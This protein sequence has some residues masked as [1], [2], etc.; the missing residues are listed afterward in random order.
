ME[1]L[2]YVHS[3]ERVDVC[4]LLTEEERRIRLF[5]K[6]TPPKPT[7]FPPTDPQY[8][9]NLA[10]LI[11][12]RLL[13][14]KNGKFSGHAKDYDDWAE[15][16]ADH[17]GTRHRDWPTFTL[18]ESVKISQTGEY[19]DDQKRKAWTRVRDL[20]AS[21]RGKLFTL[22]EYLIYFRTYW[23]QRRDTEKE[24]EDWVNLK[25][26]GS[27]QAFIRIVR[28]KASEL[29]PPAETREIVRVIYGGLKRDVRKAMQRYPKLTRPD[30]HTATEEWLDWI[31]NLDQATYTH[32]RRDRL[33][34]VETD[35][36]S[37]SSDSD[38]T[39]EDDYAETFNA[40]R[41]VLKKSRKRSDKKITKKKKGEQRKRSRRR[42]SSDAR[43]PSPS[44]EKVRKCWYCDEPG[45]F[46]RNCRK[47]KADKE[48]ENKEKEKEGKKD[49]KKRKDST[50]S[51]DSSSKN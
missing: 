41:N 5:E 28:Q 51:A 38:G 18:P 13:E 2:R 29:N 21:D 9:N 6:A 39:D 16:V 25:Q 19:L 31:V 46:A 37:T 20:P 17:W 3:T 49:K 40:I 34:A 42:N 14:I 12:N 32:S 45:H 47:K 10:Y 26:T 44:T 15:K 36:S 8:P 7:Y 22:R 1:A 33:N 27:A 43:S 35:T 23:G 11:K 4:K 30:A 50:S 48:K 24:Q